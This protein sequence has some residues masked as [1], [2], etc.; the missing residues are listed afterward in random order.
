VNKRL[1][2][3]LTTF[4]SYYHHL[5][6]IEPQ[7]PFFAAIPG[8][9]HL[10]T[11]L[12]FDYKA[13]ATDGGVEAA[14][15]WSVTHRWKLTPSY[16]FLNMIVRRNATSGDTTIE[17]TPGLSPRNQF[18]VRSFVDLPHHLEWDQTIGYVGALT[19]AA[20]PAYARIDTRFGWRMGESAEF[21]VVGQNLLRPRHPEFFDSFGLSHTEV[22]RS[23]S[24]KFT[25]RF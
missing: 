23:V 13:H 22:E 11:P 20:V 14:A 4:L 12:S 17:Q 15:T 1:S 21:S 3:D 18:S 24:I 9:P 25:W 2:V 19:T 6:T 8:P 10:V 16:T 5:Q 7:P